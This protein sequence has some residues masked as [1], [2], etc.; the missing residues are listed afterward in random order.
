MAIKF[1]M[2]KSSNMEIKYRLIIQNFEYWYDFLHSAQYYK[3]Y[4]PIFVSMAKMQRHTQ[5]WNQQN[6]SFAD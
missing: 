3:H 1:T 4:T 6:S 2:I 5:G